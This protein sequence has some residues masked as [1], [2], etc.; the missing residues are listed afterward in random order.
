VIKGQREARSRLRFAVLGYMSNILGCPLIIPV[1]SYGGAKAQVIELQRLHE[2]RKA[3]VSVPEVICETKSYFVMREIQGK[4]IDDAIA[5]DTSHS[6][7]LFLRGLQAISSVHSKG[8]C[9]SQGFARNILINGEE[10]SFLDFEDDPLEVLT[11]SQAQARDF[12]FYL[13][14]TVWLSGE[15]WP[16]WRR[17]WAEFLSKTSPQVRTPI[18]TFTKKFYWMRYLPKGRKPLGRDANRLRALAKFLSE[19][20]T[21]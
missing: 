14:S 18:E 10:C 3:G 5:S 6:T 9:L 1:P 19:E 21:V 2:L 20:S 8:L 7:V 13:V 11:L 16:A 17:C 15:N 12:L 4:P